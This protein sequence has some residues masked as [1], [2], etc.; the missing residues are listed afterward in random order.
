ML[1]KE[2]GVTYDSLTYSVPQL[3]QVLSLGDKIVCFYTKENNKHIVTIKSEDE[4]TLHAI[5]E[6]Y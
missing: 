2:E 5:V 3:G 6:L 1:S 4:Q